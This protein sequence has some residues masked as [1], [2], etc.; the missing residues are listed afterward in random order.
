MKEITVQDFSRCEVEL[1]NALRNVALEIRSVAL[2]DLASY[3]HSGKFENIA[4]I[5][6]SATELYLKPGALHFSYTCDVKLDWFGAPLVILDLELHQSG[7]D[8]YFA[9]NIETLSTRVHIRQAT[10]NGVSLR[11]QEDA[12]VF[13][14]A[15]KEAMI[16]N[17]SAQA[18]RDFSSFQQCG[19][20]DRFS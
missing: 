3:I 17:D 11:A 10:V 5:F 12:Q 14:K 1:N 19:P 8:V 20:F 2:L 18:W 16:Q 4:D 13:S 9:L 7:V 6:D 15:L